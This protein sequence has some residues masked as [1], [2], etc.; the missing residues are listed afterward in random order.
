MA[1]TT[2]TNGGTVL[3]I[4]ANS[5][6]H[7]SISISATLAVLV[8]GAAA[9]QYPSVTVSG[10]GATWGDGDTVVRL[11]LF[12]PAV[13][14]TSLTGGT[15]SACMCTGPI[16]LQTRQNPISL[17]LNFGSGVTATA[18]AVGETS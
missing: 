11:A 4:P 1:N 10:Q 17:I 2:T 5:L 9:T 16:H 12:V 14:L 6:W 15:A 8:G 7:G 13:G 3:T 18:T